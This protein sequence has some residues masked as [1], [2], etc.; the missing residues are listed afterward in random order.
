MRSFNL[1]VVLP[2]KE[3]AHNLT[4]LLE[5]IAQAVPHTQSV[6]VIVVDDGSCDDTREQVL[7]L[8][9]ALPFTCRLLC[10]ASCCGQS[11][12]VYTGVQA[13][14][15]QWIVT[16]D[17]DGQNDPA[18]IQQLIELAEKQDEAHFCIIGHRQK[19]KDTRWKLIQSRIANSVRQWALHDDTPDTGCGIKLLPAA[20]FKS[21]PYF[22]HMHRYIPALVKRLGGKVLT[23]PV[24][25]RPRVS[26]ESKYTA[27]NRGWAGVLDIIGVRWLMH[28]SHFIQ[29][30][31]KTPPQSSQH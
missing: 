14:N 1:S 6:E 22:D 29:A 21:L 16:M 26:G 25:H 12:A 3:E 15:G 13:A 20:T 5:E 7:A 31:E 28:R 2:A 18:D 27:G 4:R 17:A 30:T 19:R 24:N 11:A 23:V 9:P 10:H 8:A